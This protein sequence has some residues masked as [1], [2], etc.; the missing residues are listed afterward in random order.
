[1]F[2]CD[3]SSSASPLPPVRGFPAL[4]V[5]PANPTSTAASAF[6]RNNPFRPAYSGRFRPKTTVDLS[7]SLLLPSPSVPCAPTPPQSPA[8]SPLAVTYFCLPETTTLSACGLVLHE[9]EPLHLRYGPRVALPTLSSCCYLHEP[10]ARFPV[11]RLVP[12]AE[13]GISPAGSIRLALTHH[14]F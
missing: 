1:M 5:L 10:K 4:R 2:P 3:Q 12:L 9:A 13:A 8:T 6:L 7:G 14:S 11:G